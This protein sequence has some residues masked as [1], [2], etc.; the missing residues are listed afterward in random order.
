[1]ELGEIHN[2]TNA[3]TFGGTQKGVV[4]APDQRWNDLFNARFEVLLYDLTA[5]IVRAIRP[6]PNGDKRRHGYSRDKRPDCVQVVIGAD[7][8][9]EKAFPGL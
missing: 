1:M 7:R 2:S 6:L 9:P 8:Q 3:M 4:H 5:P